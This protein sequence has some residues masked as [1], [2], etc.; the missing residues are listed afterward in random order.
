VVFEGEEFDFLAERADFREEDLH[1]ARVLRVKLELIFI[2]L[3]V[4]AVRI[5]LRSLAGF[6]RDRLILLWVRRTQSL[7]ASYTRD[8]RA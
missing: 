8:A 6:V 1:L 7:G 4:N 3:G 5:L 2:F